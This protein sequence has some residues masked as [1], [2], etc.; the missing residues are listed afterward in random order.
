MHP[1]YGTL[2]ILFV[3]T[4]QKG[5][6]SP[7]RKRAGGTFLGRGVD[8]SSVFT[9]TKRQDYNFLPVQITLY[10]LQTIHP[11]GLVKSPTRMKSASMAGGRF[12]VICEAD[13]IE[14]TPYL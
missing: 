1:I 13:F 3:F 2:L 5:V 4:E 8:L 10:L 11:I 7:L 9:Y 6:E 14:K 12:H